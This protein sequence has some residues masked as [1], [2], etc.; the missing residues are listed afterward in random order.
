MAENLSETE[1]REIILN[2]RRSL[3]LGA[4]TI[5]H[6]GRTTTYRSQSEILD[7]ITYFESMLGETSSAP[8]SKIAR[9]TRRY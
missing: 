4:A 5:S 8:R 2:L 6:G 9:F 7:A 1:I 3:G